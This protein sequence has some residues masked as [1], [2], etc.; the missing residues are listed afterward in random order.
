M[1]KQL[2]LGFIEKYSLGNAIE[3]VAWESSNQTLKTRFVLEG[4]KS[5]L[6]DITLNKFQSAG[7]DGYKVGIFAT[8]KLV[9]LLSVLHDTFDMSL[10]VVGEKPIAINFSDEHVKVHS[11][12]SD[13]AVIPSVP[14]IKHVPSTYEVTFKITSTFA[15][16]F[17]KAKNALPDVDTFTLHTS[18]KKAQIVFG[19]TEVNT[20]NIIFNIETE[21]LTPIDDIAFN[22]KIFK[23]IL[24][25]NKDTEATFKISKEG[26]AVVEYSSESYLARYFLVA[27]GN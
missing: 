1:E 17:I 6:G 10:Q 22:A 16:D 9:S 11:A 24:L 13:L 19:A 25:A 18:G 5:V 15:S 7:F 26:L 27:R 2:L 14:N 20:N 23:Q 3:S 21:E 4:D 12:L 8:S